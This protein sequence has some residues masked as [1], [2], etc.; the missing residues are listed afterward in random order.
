MKIRFVLVLAASFPVTSLVFAQQP[1]APAPPPP[2]TTRRP[3]PVP[4]QTVADDD[5]VRITTKLVQMD[6]VVTDKNGKPVTDL[7]P[8]EVQIFE[9]GRR[10]SVTHFTYVVADALKPRPLTR[11]AVAVDKNAGPLPPAT[12]APAQV[13]RTIALVV[14]DLGLSYESIRSVRD[15]LTKFVDEQMQPGD[16]VAIIRTG[17]GVGTLQQFTVDKRMLHAAIEHIKWNPL[18][19]AG[20][21][22]I[23]RIEAS[24][25]LGLNAVDEA[26]AQAFL[27]N[28]ENLRGDAL[29]VGTVGALRYVVR[30]LGELPGRKSVLL[31]SDGVRFNYPDDRESSLRVRD[32][33]EQL[34]DLANRASVVIYSMDPRGLQPLG[35]MA[36]DNLDLRKKAGPIQNQVAPRV[37]ARST[38]FREGQN[39]LNLLA[40]QT[41]GLFVHDNNNL[42]QGLSRIMEDQQ[43]YYLVGYRPDESTFDAKIGTRKFH[44]LSLKVTRPGKFNVRMRKGFFGITD[45]EA[46]TALGTPQQQVLNAITSPFSA[47][48]VHLRLTSAFSNDAQLGSVLSSM[49]H[50]SGSDLTF[51]DEPDGW[52]QAEFD[53]V[54]ITYGDNGRIVDQVGQTDTIRVRGDSYQ[55]VLKD[56]FVYIMTVPAK[57]PGAYQLRVALRDHGS[58]QVGS[59]SQFVEVPDLTKSQLTLSSVLVNGVE[60][61]VL[62][63]AAVGTNANSASS[64][65]SGVG[66]DPKNAAAVRQ[67]RVGTI[68]KYGF[69]MYNAHL[70][71]AT[72]R[73]Q[74]QI[75]VRILRDGQPVFSG[76]DEACDLSNQSDL[77]RLNAGG[78]IQLGSQMTPGEYVFQ[79]IVT[80]P[81]AEPKHRVAT[82]WIDFEIIK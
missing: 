15:V 39:G 76:Q 17:S 28:G 29:T 34:S 80:D 21:D 42:T 47:S 5:V 7:R 81:L 58:E 54:A 57:N 65:Q 8:E 56:G 18:G 52:H 6:A 27:S 49:L 46:K 35:L 16:L 20:L 66:N 82:Q 64:N 48:A 3:A 79:V 59:A 78:G 73:P 53:V 22:A 26:N 13:R 40:E 62:Q 68:L 10:Q 37:A 71:K 50:V 9:D 75:R 24:P 2:T 69:A 30:G 14:D 36:A 25:D 70:D 23:P 67:F 32:A 61:A 74:L 12:L 63:K 31:I 45:S 51:T 19:R 33:L 55:G 77:K 43:G 1:N 4:P 11:P 60:P 44:S 72:G 41:G 38:N